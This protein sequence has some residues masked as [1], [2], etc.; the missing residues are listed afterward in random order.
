[1]PSTVDDVFAAA[2]LQPVGAVPWGA[3][4][5]EA[6]PGVYVVA[7]TADPG[8]TAAA[9]PNCPLDPAAVGTLMA[10]PEL[11][12]DR[13]PTTPEG[14]RSRLAAFWLPDEVVLYIGLAGTSLRQR[15]GQYYKTPLGK[16]SPHAGGWFLKTLTVLPDTWVHYAATDDPAGAEDRMLAAFSAAVSEASRA[17]LH[18][19]DR[20]IPFANLEWPKRRIKLHGIGGAKDRRVKPSS[21]P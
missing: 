14:L 4:V 5:P 7:L 21:R 12:V 10:R 2:G 17:A 18:D 3:P 13:L 20:P 11:T 1:M 19:S 16:R 15:V 6:G 8:S 9:L